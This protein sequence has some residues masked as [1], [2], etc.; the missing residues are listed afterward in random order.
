MLPRALVPSVLC[1]LALW[2]LGA[3]ACINSMDVSARDFSHF[4]WADLFL[5]TAGAVFLNR[6]VLFNV[7]GPAAMGQP[8]PSGFRRVFFLLVGAA[9]FLLVLV[10]AAGPLLNLNADDLASCSPSLSTVLSLVAFPAVL[11]SLHAAFF[12]S[13]GRRLF[14]DTGRRNVVSMVLTSALLVV[15]LWIARELYI[16]PRLCRTGT[17]F[18]TGSDY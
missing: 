4:F 2:P 9:L 10:S 14:G 11:F 17:S 16:I 8:E 6:V 5:W 12:H 3:F 13:P 1:V 18:F 7:L 15:G